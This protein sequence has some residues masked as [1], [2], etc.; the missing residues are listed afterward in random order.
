MRALRSLA[1]VLAASFCLGAAAE[2]GERLTDPVQ[3]A[4][5]KALFAQVRCVVCQNESIDDSEADLAADL[6]KIVRNEVAQGQS[7]R[8][9]KAFLI[10]RYGEF[11]MLK[12]AFSLG[13]APLWLVPFAIV[14]LGGLAMLVQVRRGLAKSGDSPASEPG[15][16][17]H[18]Q[19]KLAA[20]L[21][22]EDK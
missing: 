4:R 6:R 16:T 9:I 11:I 22:N 13:N 7:D 19:E 14:V 17:K 2:P 8:Q 5:A 20:L 21:G 12:P 18:E 1:L 3:E 10:A 15:L